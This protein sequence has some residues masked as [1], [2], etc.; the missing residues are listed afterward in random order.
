MLGMLEYETETE[1]GDDEGGGEMTGRFEAVEKVDGSDRI[2]S[3]K[4]DGMLLNEKTS[5]H[6]R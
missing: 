3:V 6:I 4:I 1:S 5:S 2:F